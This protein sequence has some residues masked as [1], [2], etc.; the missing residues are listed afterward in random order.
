MLL[1]VLGNLDVI[2]TPPALAA[3]ARVQLDWSATVSVRVAALH[4]AISLWFVGYVGGGS[5]GV[6]GSRGEGTMPAV[7][8][9]TQDTL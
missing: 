9:H 2:E 1:Y 3:D 8:A 4:Q 5:C 7:P 6:G